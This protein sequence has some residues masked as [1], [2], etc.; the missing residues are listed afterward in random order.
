M[1]TGESLLMDLME[2]TQKKMDGREL[3]DAHAVAQ[4]VAVGA[5]KYAVLKQ[6]E[7]QGYHL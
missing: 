5:I 3:K 4:E 2:E 6:G 1:I 7:R